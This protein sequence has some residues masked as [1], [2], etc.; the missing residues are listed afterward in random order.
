MAACRREQEYTGQPS[1]ALSP[2]Q[3]RGIIKRVSAGKYYPT[4]K[5]WDVIERSCRIKHG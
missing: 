2:L 1:H 3:R 4:A 5:G